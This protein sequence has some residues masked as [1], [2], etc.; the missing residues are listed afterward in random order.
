MTSIFKRIPNMHGLW[1]ALIMLCATSTS[2]AQNLVYNAQEAEKALGFDPGITYVPQEN[3]NEPIICAHGFG[4]YGQWYQNNA[5]LFKKSLIAFNF[6]DRAF[7]N[8]KTSFLGKL[9]AGYSI[10]LGQERDVKTLLF[11]LKTCVQN[12]FKKVHAFGHSRGAATW[13]RALHVLEMPTNVE[14]ALILK[15]VGID[16]AM[17]NN[18]KNMLVPGSIILTS[19]LLDL[20]SSLNYQMKKTIFSSISRTSAFVAALFIRM[21]TQCNLWC[22]KPINLFQELIRKSRYKFF[23]SIVPK[24]D[25]LGSDHIDT[26]TDL[27]QNS[28]TRLRLLPSGEDHNDIHHI[29]QSCH[30]LCRN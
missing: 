4:H 21:I 6:S 22:Q 8:P 18:I 12:G 10:N 29:I 19:P 15:T 26:I 13:I 5:H 25:L 17:R 23:V 30:E 9:W 14:N 7:F 24:D 27:S 2:S 16:E 11:V 1:L 28:Q 20:Y 3:D